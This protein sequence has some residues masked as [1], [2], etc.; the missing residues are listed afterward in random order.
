MEVSGKT[1]PDEEDNDE[2]GNADDSQDGPRV[3]SAVLRRLSVDST[4]QLLQSTSKLD[5]SQAEKTKAW[6]ENA[7]LLVEVCKG[8]IVCGSNL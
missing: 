8:M 3:T 4:W 2:G 5:G 6:K 7:L 1:D